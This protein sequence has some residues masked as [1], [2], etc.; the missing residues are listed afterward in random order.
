VEWDA[1][2]SDAE[3][4]QQIIIYTAESGSASEQAIRILASWAAERFDPPRSSTKARLDDAERGRRKS[5]ITRLRCERAI[6]R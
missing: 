4:D 3:P 6:T 1:L 2:T 5:F